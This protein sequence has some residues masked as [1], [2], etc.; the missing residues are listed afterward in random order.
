M[1][2][3][4]D[5]PS[6]QFG[7]EPVRIGPDKKRRRFIIVVWLGII[8]FV[9]FLIMAYANLLEVAF[10]SQPLCVPHAKA[11]DLSQSGYSAAKSSC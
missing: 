2:S 5:I 11:G 6:S 8:A 3:L 7:V 4:P 10:E 1:D 9:V